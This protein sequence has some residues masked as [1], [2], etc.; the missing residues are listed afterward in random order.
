MFYKH[1]A[2]CIPRN[3]IPWGEIRIVAAESSLHP[4]GLTI[5]SLEF[6][7]DTLSRREVMRWCFILLETPFDISSS[8]WGQVAFSEDFQE[9]LAHI[10]FCLVEIFQQLSQPQQ[11]TFR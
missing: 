4:L 3:E 7:Q 2:L 1:C 6:H 8:A 10:F 5:C 9:K 11:A